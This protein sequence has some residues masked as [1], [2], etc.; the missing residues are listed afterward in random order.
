M[1]SYTNNRRPSLASSY[2]KNSLN[3]SVV[4]F[5]TSVVSVLTIDT[6]TN[7]LQL[8]GVSKVVKIV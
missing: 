7:L 1:L 5:L 6:A 4:S 3:F 2:N 8:S